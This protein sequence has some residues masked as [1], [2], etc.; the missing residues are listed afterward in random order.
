VRSFD[1]LVVISKNLKYTY[2]DAKAYAE[3]TKAIING[4][5]SLSDSEREARV[6]LV[7]DFVAELPERDVNKARLLHTLEHIHMNG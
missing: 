1:E 6:Q 5:A 7:D 2:E 4:D 3:N